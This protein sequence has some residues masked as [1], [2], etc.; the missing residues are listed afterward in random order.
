MRKMELSV[1]ISVGPDTEEV[2]MQV[3]GTVT[4]YVR[5]TRIDPAE[6]GDVEDLEVGFTILN[7]QN[8]KIVYFDFLP[9]LSKSQLEEIEDRFREHYIECENGDREEAM[10][11]KLEQRREER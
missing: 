11:R 1:E 8:T 6:G 5:A 2:M 4:P 9:F 10:E 7:S 3:S